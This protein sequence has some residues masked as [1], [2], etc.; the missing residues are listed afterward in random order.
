MFFSEN[1]K[2][3]EVMKP[4]D[5]LLKGSYRQPNLRVVGKSSTKSQNLRVRGLFQYKDVVSPV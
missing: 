5:R 4:Q 1:D 2:N 3:L